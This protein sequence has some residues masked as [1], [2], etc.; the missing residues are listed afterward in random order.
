MR[1]GP[2]ELQNPGG[3]LRCVPCDQQ[4][5]LCYS[6]IVPT[7]LLDGGHSVLAA[8][9]CVLGSGIPAGESAAVSP[10]SW[11]SLEQGPVCWTGRCFIPGL[12]PRVKPIPI[13]LRVWL[14]LS[15]STRAQGGPRQSL[16]EAHLH[17]QP[18]TWQGVEDTKRSGAAQPTVRTKGRVT[19]AW[20][21]VLLW[22]LYPC[23]G[24]ARQSGHR[25]TL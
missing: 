5:V 18:L 11:H 10:V 13:L 8:R 24:K 17:G 9:A 16:D 15:S 22:L 14:G 23:T 6:P 4:R 21:P 25:D 19:M 3:A 7:P 12:A 2:G 20:I 1:Q